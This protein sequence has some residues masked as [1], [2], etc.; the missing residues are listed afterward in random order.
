[1]TLQS[2]MPIFNAAVV[3]QTLS[4]RAFSL[5]LFRL[6]RHISIFCLIFPLPARLR[7]SRGR[8]WAR[9]EVKSANPRAIYDGQHS[10]DT[11]DLLSADSHQ[12]GRKNE[13]NW[14]RLWLHRPRQDV[15]EAPAAQGY[16]YA[17][18]SFAG[19]AGQFLMLSTSAEYKTGKASL[20]AQGKRRYDRKQA[21]LGTRYASKTE[22]SGC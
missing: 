18:P 5:H 11:Q 15:Q 6:F 22:D 14:L 9:V 20:F 12:D 19:A 17:A 1:M 8:A 13:Q 10:Q 3:M 4:L 21:S 16:P 7:L 2:V